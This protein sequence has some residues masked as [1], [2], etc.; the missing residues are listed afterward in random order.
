M[1]DHCGVSCSHA[2]SGDGDMGQ[3]HSME[4]GEGDGLSNSGPWPG[5]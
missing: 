1:V 5:Y 2:V 4:W 3:G